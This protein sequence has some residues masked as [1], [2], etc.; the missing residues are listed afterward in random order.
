MKQIPNSKFQILPEGVLAPQGWQAAA[1]CAY[2]KGS[3]GSKL[4]VGLLASN[5]DCAAAG[6][7]TQNQ[8]KAPPVRWC[9]QHLPRRNIRAI[10]ANSGN[11][12]ACTGE[13][14][15]QDAAAMASA[16]AQS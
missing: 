3:T 6:V 10:V 4:D 5:R 8:V 16:A 7:F 11:A 1:T 2:I 14:G 13:Q 12:N 15:C 9:Q